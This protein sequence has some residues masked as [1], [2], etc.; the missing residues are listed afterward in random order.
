MAGLG[1]NDGQSFP[2]RK[3]S[4]KQHKSQSGSC[5]RPTRLD[6][7]LKVQSQ[8]LAEEEVLSG[9]STPRPQA[10]PD[11]PQGTQ[12]KIEH[13]QQYVTQEIE[14]RHQGQDRIPRTLSSLHGVDRGVRNYCGQ[15][16]AWSD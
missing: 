2:P 5:V 11:E 4:G 14:F 15:Q 9:Q 8:W 12:Q 16:D 1:L 3:K 6:L 10:D 13:D 7:A